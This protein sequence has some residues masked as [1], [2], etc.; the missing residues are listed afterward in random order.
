MPAC[1]CRMRPR[2]NARPKRPGK[3]RRPLLETPGV[4]YVS[5]VM[6]Y[7]MLSGVNATYSSFF[8][9]SLKPWE[10]RKTPETSYDGI[11]AHLQQALSQGLIGNCV[12]I[13]AARN[14]G[15][16]DFRRSH[17]HS[18]RPVGRRH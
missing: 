4:Q 12:L 3:S 7:S 2:C 10:E 9:V 14:S 13:S 11:K 16:R 8:F 18:G 15:R 17:F 6:G 1:N 5:S